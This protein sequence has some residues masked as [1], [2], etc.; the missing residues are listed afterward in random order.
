M[1]MREFWAVR[2][3][4]R[5]YRAQFDTRSRS[6]LRRFI[7]SSSRN[8]DLVRFLFFATSLERRCFLILAGLL[9]WDVRTRERHKVNQPGARSK[10]I[11]FV[12]ISR[13]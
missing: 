4:N 7:L 5:S 6:T 13:L 11:W 8:F 9:T 3:A 1:L 10:W 12:F 2:A